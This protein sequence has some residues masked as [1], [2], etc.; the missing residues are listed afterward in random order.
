MKF[1]ANAVSTLYFKVSVKKRPY[2][3]E[4]ISL[5]ISASDFTKTNEKGKVMLGKTLYFRE[6]PLFTEQASVDANIAQMCKVNNFSVA[7]VL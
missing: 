6:M 3:N 4:E 5:L 2:S 7:Q 1:S